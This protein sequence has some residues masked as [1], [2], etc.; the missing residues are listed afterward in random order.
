MTHG[1][2]PAVALLHL[3]RVVRVAF[4][5]NPAR[6][7]HVHGDLPGRQLARHRAAP[8]GLRA[9][10]GHVGAE[11]MRAAAEHLARDVDD[12]AVLRLLHVRQHAA[13]DEVRA[14][15]EEVEHLLVEGPVVFLDRLQLLV[16]RGVVDGNVH[17]PERRLD[18]GDH[19]VH[20]GL[21]DDVGAHQHA[22]QAGVGELVERALRV[23]V[24]VGVVD[25]HLG[26][27]LAQRERHRLAKPARCAGD[28]RH[29]SIQPEVG[30]L[31]RGV[32]PYRVK[33][34]PISG[35]D[36]S[37]EI[38]ADLTRHPFR[39]SRRGSGPRLPRPPASGRGRR[40]SRSARSG[41]G[42]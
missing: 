25:G 14:L 7:H 5:G 13:R 2:H 32:N 15:H 40:R 27:G 4:H 33:A 21:V 16:G 22:L 39:R 11:G 26:A 10:R 19:A 37:G 18:L 31:H 24:G 36:A 38:G 34:T 20:F 30:G 17:G 35:A 3:L 29:A 23:L 1:D 41:R 42:P 8:A 6:R 9:L 28:Q 12:A